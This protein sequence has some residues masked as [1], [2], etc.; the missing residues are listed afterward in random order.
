MNR[1]GQVWWARWDS[2]VTDFEPCVILARKDWGNDCDMPVGWALRP[3]E[4]LADSREEFCHFESQFTLVE[5]GGDDAW[6]K[7]RID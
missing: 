3:L 4:R 2:I 6:V 5:N 1:V 7:C